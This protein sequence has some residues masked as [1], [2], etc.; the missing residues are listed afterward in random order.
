MCYLTF[1]LLELNEYIDVLEAAIEFKN[2]SISSKQ[3]DVGH[4]IQ[5]EHETLTEIEQKFSQLSPADAQSLLVR[6]FDKVVLLR[7]RE[8]QQGQ[9]RRELEGQVLEQTEVVRRLEKSLKHAQVDAERRLV[10]QQKVRDNSTVFI[11]TLNEP[12]SRTL[13]LYSL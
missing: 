5:E 10:S 11:L 2:D 12:L 1:R 13:T 7:L 4:M 9:S 6:Y 3:L 8:G